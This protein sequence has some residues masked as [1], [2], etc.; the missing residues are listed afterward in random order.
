LWPLLGLSSGLRPAAHWK[1]V[2]DTKT[3]HYKY[4]AV[5]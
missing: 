2:L 5:Y 4:D 1:A 3:N